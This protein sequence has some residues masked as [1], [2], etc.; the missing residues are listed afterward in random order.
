MNVLD[1]F[2]GLGGWSAPFKDRGHN[3]LTVDNNKVFKPDVLA[4]IEFLTADDLDFSPDIV[5]ASPPCEAFSVM[6]V[7]KNWY[8]DGTPKT[9]KAAKAIELVQATIH[10]IED[11]NPT[12]WIIENPI[13]KLRKLG[14]LDDYQNY[15][16][17][18]CQYGTP[19]MKPTDLWGVFPRSFIP[20]PKCKNGD[21][22]HM[23]M[24]RGTKDGIQMN[25]PKFKGGMIDDMVK[26]W[27]K[28]NQRTILR[29]ERSIVPYN[30]GLDVCLAAE[31][32][33][34]GGTSG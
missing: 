29:A 19:Y 6:T 20:K 18:Y 31:E 16:I 27:S 17:T 33:I 34:F 28:S 13:G 14:L 1:L 5:L 32:D 4:D 23:N 11:L 12:F 25:K 22:C 15:M 21:T 3:I 10:L 26:Y 24:P 30:L 2:S 8:H 9:E 7:G